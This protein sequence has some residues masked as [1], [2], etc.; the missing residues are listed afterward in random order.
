ML[1]LLY[2]A[3]PAL[4]GAAGA[5]AFRICN[6]KNTTSSG[7]FGPGRVHD[8]EALDHLQQGPHIP[9]DDGCA[10]LQSAM[11]TAGGSGVW[12]FNKGT[13]QLSLHQDVDPAKG[14]E[15]DQV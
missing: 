10:L 12:V 4:A 5:A 15:I 7:I 3:L 9:S 14:W 8:R 11:P 1:K 6:T 13:G 2:L